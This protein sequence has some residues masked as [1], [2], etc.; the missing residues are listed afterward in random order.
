M[1]PVLYVAN[2]SGEVLLVLVGLV[3]LV[4]LV[5][6]VLAFWGRRAWTL[7]FMLPTAQVR[8]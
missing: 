8:R 5:V 1:D 6:L 2:R 4:V 3:V 7:Y